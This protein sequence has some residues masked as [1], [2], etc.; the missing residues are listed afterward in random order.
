MLKFGKKFKKKK[1]YRDL[2]FEYSQPIMYLKVQT[3]V[4]A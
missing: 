1:I 3:I 4:K 2:K